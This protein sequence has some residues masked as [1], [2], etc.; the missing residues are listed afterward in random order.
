MSFIKKSS[1]AGKKQAPMPGPNSAAYKR[2]VAAKKN[3]A[4]KGA[5]KPNKKQ[6]TTAAFSSLKSRQML[7]ERAKREIWASVLK[8]NEAI[9]KLAQAGNFNAA[10]ALF[11]FA[12]VYSLPE[13][14]EESAKGAAGLAAAVVES[15]SKQAETDPVDAFFRSIGLPET[16]AEAQS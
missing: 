10:K 16:C 9:I 15:A 7:V 2:I 3:G 5:G 11:D 1:A 4:V 13:P 12:G 14:E 8:I 6:K